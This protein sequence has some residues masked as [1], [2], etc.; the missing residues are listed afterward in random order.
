[1]MAG[2]RAKDTKPEIFVRSLLHRQGYRFRLQRKDLPGKP[3]VVLS[4]LNTVIFVHGCFWHGHDD[5]SIFRLPKSNT[6]FWS[7]KI[8]TNKARDR[9][10]R[11]SYSKSSWRMIEIWECAL[12]GRKRQ[13][14]AK[15]SKALIEALETND[16]H[17]SI[18][19]GHA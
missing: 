6:K 8:E 17:V 10:T 1:M 11:E 13:E 16:R 2:I 18:R 3:D 15:F 12:K 9:R 14:E 7:Q 19:G 5:C 4:K